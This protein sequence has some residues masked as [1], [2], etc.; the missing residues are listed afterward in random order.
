MGEVLENGS[1]GLSKR[2]V[3]A[4]VFLASFLLLTA[5]LAN[6]LVY[7]KYPLL[8]LEVAAAVFWLGSA[9]ALLSLLYISTGLW[10]RRLM[11]ALLVAFVAD[12]N[13]EHTTWPLV[14]GGGYFLLSWFLREAPHKLLAIF[15]GFVLVSSLLGLG[16]SKAW[17]T[18]TKTAGKGPPVQTDR[19]AIVHVLLDEHV[20]IEGFHK[21]ESGVQT[22]AKLREFYLANNFH[23]YGKAYSQ[24]LDTVNAIPHILNFGTKAADT[25]S[26]KGAVVGRTAYFDRLVDSGYDLA[27][28]QSDYADFC[29]G[30]SDARC[31]TYAHGSL[32]PL[33]EQPMTVPERTTLIMAKFI[34]MSQG[35]GELGRRVPLLD[36]MA[37]H[38]GLRGPTSL[39]RLQATGTVPALRVFDGM[40]ADLENA[41]GGQAYFSHALFPHYPYTVTADCSP[42]PMS[43]WKRSKEPIP[44]IERTNAYDEQALCAARQIEKL[45]AA[46]ERSPARDNFVMIVHGDHGSRLTSLNPTYERRGTFKNADLVAGFSTLFAVRVPGE[47]GA[48]SDTMVNAAGILKAVSDA[49]FAASPK[50][51]TDPQPYIFIADEDWKPRAKE[52]MP[53]QW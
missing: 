25:A 39:I 6:Y 32:Q 44:F 40:A 30:Y 20:G 41:R 35:V 14:A 53:S 1:T 4:G 19:P 29:D 23:V 33:L 2:G 27:I 43:D 45:L 7:D 34:G 49:D 10:T 13:I 22:S 12:I 42:K 16:E 21:T 8:R 36:Q 17:L 31:I 46:L 5:S 9:C 47:R 51:L 37:A 24:H 18:E 38:F 50:L 48:Y 3:F 11:D 28:Y 26:R 52:P 15:G